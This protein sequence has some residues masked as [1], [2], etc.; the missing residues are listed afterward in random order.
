MTKLILTIVMLAALLLAAGGL[1]L[2]RKRGE[3][4]RG[5]LMLATAL[6]LIGNVWIWSLPTPG[7][8]QTDNRISR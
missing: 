4:Q 5:L 7:S 8:T 2:W 6:V 3:R 1:Y